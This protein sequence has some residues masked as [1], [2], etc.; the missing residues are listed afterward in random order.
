M[1]QRTEEHLKHIHD[2]ALSFLDSQ[3]DSLWKGCCASCC[4]YAGYL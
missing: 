4:L 2:V 3:S 1:Y